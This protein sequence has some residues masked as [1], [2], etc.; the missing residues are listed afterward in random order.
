MEIILWALI[1][2]VLF[3]V[4]KTLELEKT[5]RIYH[6]KELIKRYFEIKNINSNYRIKHLREW[7]AQAK[8][9]VEK[10]EKPSVN[11]VVNLGDFKVIK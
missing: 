7:E 6:E 1:F 9:I 10:S 8:L 2:I 4:F 11:N 5:S 3:A